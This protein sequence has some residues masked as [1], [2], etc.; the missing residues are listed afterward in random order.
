[1]RSPERRRRRR[2]AACRR[3]RV[4]RKWKIREAE[5]AS[6]DSP[7]RASIEEGQ[8]QSE[9]LY[10]EKASE[11]TDWNREG[12]FVAAVVE[13]DDDAVAAVADDAVDAMKT[14]DAAAAVVVVVG[15]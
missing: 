9:N 8:N 10:S 15:E 1:M 11:W 2:K 4:R 5:K 7:K 6:M 13:I 14:A 12:H 3:A